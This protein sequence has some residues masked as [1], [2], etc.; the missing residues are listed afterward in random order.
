MW[1]YAAEG[2]I[3][4]DLCGA[5]NYLDLVAE[6]ATCNTIQV[7]VMFPVPSKLLSLR[8]YGSYILLCQS[9]LLSNYVSES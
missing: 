9:D 7:L 3:S 8:V 6:F 1:E 5:F 4:P 2:V